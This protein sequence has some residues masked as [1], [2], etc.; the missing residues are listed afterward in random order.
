MDKKSNKLKSAL[1]TLKLNKNST[2]KTTKNT[3]ART[4]KHLESIFDQKSVHLSKFK[5]TLRK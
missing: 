1:T 2:R 5:T 3:S 4:P